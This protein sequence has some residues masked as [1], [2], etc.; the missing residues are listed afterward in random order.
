MA[1]SHADD[2]GPSIGLERAVR[3]HACDRMCGRRCNH[4]DRRAGTAILH[5]LP[6]TRCDS[7]AR[8][9]H[10]TVQTWTGVTRQ[11]SVVCHAKN[12]C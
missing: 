10:A 9:L 5:T 1:F 3:V 11:H 8:V 12:Y 2:M 4:A 7:I 6:R